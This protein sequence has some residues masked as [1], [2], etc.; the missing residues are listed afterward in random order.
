MRL[1]S[2]GRL[3]ALAAALVLVLVLAACSG[4]ASTSIG[5]P[6]AT[7]PSS[8]W[9][10]YTDPSFGFS[11]DVPTGWVIHR[12]TSGYYL[13]QIQDEDPHSTLSTLIWSHST[14][15]HWRRS[16]GASPTPRRCTARG[17][18]PRPSAATR[19]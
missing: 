1:T 15:P 19:R 8:T 6:T 17:R 13:L 7:A 16:R 10:R 14:L 18:R 9:A 12:S 4:S 11:L 5:V 3:V 2:L